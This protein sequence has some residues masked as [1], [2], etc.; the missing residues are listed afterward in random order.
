MS[1]LLLV[2]GLLLL[3][4]G[5]DWVVDTAAKFAEQ[6]GVP[7]FITG[8]TLVAMGTSAPEAAIGILAGLKG[9]NQIALGDVIGSSIINITLIIGLTA[10]IFPLLVDPLLSRREIPLSF[11]IQ[12]VL[13]GMLF[14]G[15]VLSRVE[16]LLLITGL[17][18]FVAYIGIKTIRKLERIEPADAEEAEMF[19][20]LQDQEVMFEAVM[21]SDEL[22]SGTTAHE[23]TP[24]IKLILLFILGLAA[25]V[26]GAQLVVDSST[27]IAHTLVLSEEFIGLTIVAFGTSLPELVTCLVAALRQKAD[28]AVG[29]VIGSNIFNIL[30]VLGLSSAISPISAPPEVFAD[31]TAML[32]ATL[33]L[34]VLVWNKQKISRLSGITL[35]AFYF[36]YMVWKLLS[37]S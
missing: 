29:N 14:T 26:A 2:T 32:L 20:F 36:L 34:L 28:I 5:V 1:Y 35:M 18:I 10:A 19:E 21:D 24:L 15:L 9:A 25:M 37:L 4:K 31:L 16:S 11:F 8:L 3:V 13:T 7:A 6:W 23:P 17:L 22:R 12:L 33:L 30:C 27:I